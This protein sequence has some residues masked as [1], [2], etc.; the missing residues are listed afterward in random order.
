MLETIH[1][2]I[3]HLYIPSSLIILLLLALRFIFLCC[4]RY[5]LQRG[6]TY[7]WFQTFWRNA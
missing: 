5:T 6:N 1:C 3:R 2:G 4:M 7:E